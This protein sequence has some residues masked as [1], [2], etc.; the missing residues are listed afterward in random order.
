M[1]KRIA[2]ASYYS[3]GGTFIDWSIHFLNNQDLYFDL[4]NKKWINLTSNPITSSNAHGHKKNHP[5]SIN[6]VQSYFANSSQL[7][8]SSIVSFYAGPEQYDTV[9]KELNISA[10]QFEDPEIFNQ[11]HST[12]TQS[13]KKLVEF[14]AIHCNKLIVINY[15]NDL[16]SSLYLK[17]GRAQRKFESDSPYTDA[18]ELFFARS[19]TQWKDLG[20]TNIWDIREQTA[21]NQRLIELPIDNPV[22][23]TNHYWLDAREFW[24]NGKQQILSIMK[25]LEL[26]VDTDRYNTWMSIFD[27]W[28]EIQSKSLQF[29]LTCKHIVN[30]IVE[31]SYYELPELSF[32]Q[33]AI[34]QHFLIYRFNLNLKTWQLTSFPKNTQDLHKLLETNIHPIDNAYRELLTQFY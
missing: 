21:L 17:Q 22:I 24:I 14:L 12:R 32:E 28:Q 13:Y 4:D 10:S 7:L 15:S 1:T 3:V 25:Y 18:R 30:S 6:K 26:D 34:I 27:Q 2:I 8:D 9:A 29:S 16:W 31:N 11:I 5:F 33:E 20:L 23:K 19:S